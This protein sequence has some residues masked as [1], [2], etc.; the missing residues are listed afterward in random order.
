MFL[1]KNRL[2]KEKDFKIV[3]KQG[4]YLQSEFVKLNY[5][6]NN[7][8]HSRFGV[9]AS[10]KVSKKAVVRNKLK[11]QYRELIKKYLLVLPTSIDLVLTIKPQAVGK[12]YQQL[13]D[14]FINKIIKFVRF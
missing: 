12:D 4:R 5:L 7:L 13:K 14:N 1:K 11:R 9:I 2:Q 8:E 10:L 6:K 3:F